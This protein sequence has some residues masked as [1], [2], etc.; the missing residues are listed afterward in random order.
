MYTR[1]SM[2]LESDKAAFDAYF[3]ALAEDFPKALAGN[4]AA[5]TRSRKALSEMT[6]LAKPLR[7]GLLEPKGA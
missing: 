6:K 7:K 4:K 1:D 5:A 2:T 3:A